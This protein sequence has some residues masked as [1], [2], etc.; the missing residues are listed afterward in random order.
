MQGFVDFLESQIKTRLEDDEVGETAVLGVVPSHRTENPTG[1][2]V[3]ARR[4]TL[5]CPLGIVEDKQ[6]LGFDDV[7]S[8]A[9]A[10][11]EQ[12]ADVGNR[13]QGSETHLGP[14]V[15]D[16]VS[17]VLVGPCSLGRG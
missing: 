3:C 16:E 15:A 14:E 6:P 8:R 7:T 1:R 9:L 12:V 10:T 11:R 17:R 4:P 5:L 13:G 2:E